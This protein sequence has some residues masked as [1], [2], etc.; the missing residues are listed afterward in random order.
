[1][2]SELFLISARSAYFLYGFCVVYDFYFFRPR[3][4]QN[5]SWNLSIFRYTLKNN[6]FI[7][8]LVCGISNI[9]WQFIFP[10]EAGIAL[11]MRSQM[12]MFL[13]S[14]LDHENVASKI[15]KALNWSTGCGKTIR[16]RPPA[17]TRGERSSPSATAPL[18][19]LLTRGFTRRLAPIS[20]RSPSNP[21]KILRRIS[22]SPAKNSL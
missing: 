13:D 6:W 17:V 18:F 16:P 12:S 10:G 21:C 1:M 7:T 8:C 22:A 9:F 15:Q 14:T 20:K 5:I 3:S 2:I 4:G 19:K 11:N